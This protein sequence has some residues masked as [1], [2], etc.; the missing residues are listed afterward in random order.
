[1]TPTNTV[2]P[3]VTPSVTP[4]LP[5][6]ALSVSSSSVQ[7][8]Y[9]L[10]DA[11]FTL[12]A[13][14]GNGASYEYS[15]DNVN[16]QT[17]ATFSSLA[18]TTYTGY[19]RNSNRTGTVTSVS[20]GSLARSA[21]SATI[22]TSNYNG[23]SIACNGGTDSIVV[24][25]LTGGQG[26]PYQVKLNSG[27][28]YQTTTTSRTYSNLSAGSHTIYVK[29]SVGCEN[30]ISVTLTQPT[31]VTSSITSTTLPTC[32]NDANGSLTATAGGGVGGYTYSLNGGAYQASAT[33]SSLANGTYTVTSK[34]ANGCA[35]TS[36]SITLNRTAPNATF[37]VSN[38]SGYNV[39]CNGGAD[40][41]I[42]VSGGSGGSG[43]GY[44]ASTDNVTYYAL[45]KTFGSLT[46]ASSPYTIYIKDSSGC[47]QSYDTAITQP[48]AQAATA[49]VI[50][51]DD[52]T[53]IGQIDVAVS[54]GAGLKTIRLYLDSSTPYTDFSK[55]TLVATATGVAN[56]TTYSFTGLLCSTGR[57]W[58]EVTDANGCVIN[59]NSV[60]LCGYYYIGKYTSSN[61]IQCTPT[62]NLVNTYLNYTHYTTYVAA[63]NQLQ[64]GMILYKD[65][66]GTVYT[67]TR[68]YDPATTNIW[69]VAANGTIGANPY[70]QC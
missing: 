68:I 31:A 34:D 29:D 2:T 6:L 3:T 66:S 47:I 28:T 10:S 37:T 50:A 17:S 26:A 62:G 21:P 48:P 4:S 64:P 12:S 16:W 18:G 36:S 13:S 35:T 59:S 39:S 55:T 57:H 8:C 9:N 27:G 43:T 44:S 69:P 51:T 20:V 67:T 40:G 5:A 60:Q 32:Y 38:Y 46:A 11:S 14:G 65:S 63:G 53:G 23:Y 45:P 41:S 52:G 61:T 49:T 25:S 70:Q 58:A 30:T 56:A 7:S 22:T 19:V 1:V 24:S 54:G 33:F 42:A 15:K